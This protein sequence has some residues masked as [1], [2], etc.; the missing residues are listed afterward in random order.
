MKTLDII[1]LVYGYT[2]S[3]ILIYLID[4]GMNKRYQLISSGITIIIASCYALFSVKR[5]FTGI[6][7]GFLTLPIFAVLAFN[8]VAIISWKI[9]GREFRA[10][11]R[12]ARYFYTE[13]KNWSDYLLSFFV[14]IIELGWPILTAVLWKEF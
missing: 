5:Q 12:G 1:I 9:C 13:K 2:F 11:W 14:I 10:T 4:H 6:N 8:S 3:T 7:Y